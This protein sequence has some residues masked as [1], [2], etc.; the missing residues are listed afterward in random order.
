MELSI[1]KE[2]EIELNSEVSQAVDQVDAVLKEISDIKIQVLNRN[3]I[4]TLENLFEFVVE[5]MELVEINSKLSSEQKQLVVSRV[6]TEFIEESQRH[7][8]KSISNSLISFMLPKI[9]QFILTNGKGLKEINEQIEVVV[10]KKKSILINT[11]KFFKKILIAMYNSLF[12]VFRKKQ[13]T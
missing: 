6:A 8:I 5:L 3:L 10:K 13:Q 4:L 9:I 7:E 2:D 11:Y 1:K 12:C